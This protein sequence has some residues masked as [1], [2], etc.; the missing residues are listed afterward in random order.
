MKTVKF[1]HALCIILLSTI[2]IFSACK[3]DEN[4]IVIPPPGNETLTQQEIEDII[5]SDSLISQRFDSISN[6]PDPVNGLKILAEY[7][8]VLPSVEKSVVADDNSIII[9]YKKGGSSI[10]LLM[11]C[12]TPAPEPESQEVYKSVESI[13]NEQNIIGNNQ[14]I[15]IDASWM[16]VYRRPHYTQVINSLQS[17]FMAQDFSVEVLRGNVAGVNIFKN[18]LNNY[19]VIY[20]L[21]HG[22]FDMIWNTHWI[23]TG[24]EGNL[25]YVLSHYGEDWVM[26]RVA[27]MQVYET[28]GEKQVKVSYCG[29]SEKLISHY[30]K[31]ASKHFPNS[32]VYIS[33]CMSLYYNKTFAQSFCDN[34][35]GAFVGWNNEQ[36]KGYLSGEELIEQMLQGYDLINA[37]NNIDA[38]YKT[39]TTDHNSCPAGTVIVNML[40][41]PLTSGNLKLIE[42]ANIPPSKPLC[43]YPVHLAEDIPLSIN[44]IWTC[45]DEDSESLTYDI[46]LGESADP[47]LLIS[48]CSDTSYP[49]QNLELNTTYY[50]RIVAKDNIDETSS[51]LWSFKTFQN[52]VI[53][54]PCK[55]VPF[56]YSLGTTVYGQ[57]SQGYNGDFSCYS[58]VYTEHGVRISPWYG[59]G[60]VYFDYGPV[61]GGSVSVTFQWVD[62][63]W[64]SDWKQLQVFNW[65]TQLWETIAQW[66]G[67]DG[68]EHFNSHAIDINA[69]RIGP[70]GQIRVGIWA[71]SSAVIHL[72]SLSVN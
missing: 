37:Y 72:N 66:S 46:Y 12:I 42:G 2:I 5:N 33:A 17:M 31:S 29:V 27:D 52:S 44:L 60:R 28:R 41:Y 35:A 53:A 14:V 7:A 1:N 62:N 34:G 8:N 71:G 36:C 57:E 18:T 48:N 25:N 43:I 11:N 54:G 38:Y 39:D 51:D 15:I 49:L 45:T 10:K 6:S 56:M 61:S 47:P 22:K 30:Y 32:L 23:Q 9:K 70:A 24:E 67:N 65:T 26:G 16:D 68:L 13:N 4:D 3:K 58:D 55:E 50:W 63:A 19:G 21:G 59:D 69:D 40:Y 20:Y 64:W